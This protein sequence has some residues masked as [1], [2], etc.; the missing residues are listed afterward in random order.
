MKKLIFGFL[1]PVAATS[2]LVVS[3]VAQQG[4]ATRGKKMFVDY[5]CYACHGFSGQNG[6]GKRLVPMKMAT[7]VFTAYVRSPGTNQMPS[8]SAKVL[9]D[10]QLAD[11]WAYIKTLPDSP[12]AKDIPLVQQLK[13]EAG[14]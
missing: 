6:P 4:D 11:I 14:K 1:A 10:A 7:V 5:S 9:S 2:L 3:A 12:E 8:Y 13:A